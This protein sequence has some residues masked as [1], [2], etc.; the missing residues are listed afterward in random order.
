M[1]KR[2]SW[3]CIPDKIHSEENSAHLCVP[4]KESARS[5]MQF[6]RGEDSDIEEE[7]FELY[8][9]IEATKNKA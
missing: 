2:N 4:L 3:K 7:L 9:G 1:E 6:L 8:E 5:A